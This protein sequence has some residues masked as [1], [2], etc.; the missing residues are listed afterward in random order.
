M[1]MS[2]SPFIESIRAEM[3]LR[4][5]VN[6]PRG[7]GFQISDK[8]TQYSHCTECRR[9]IKNNTQHDRNA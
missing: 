4:G 8:T 3:R 1:Y 2:A 9:S 5:V 7:F 6:R